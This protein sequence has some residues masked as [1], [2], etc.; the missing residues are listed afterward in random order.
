LALFGKIDIRDLHRICG[1]L[2]VFITLAAKSPL[3]AE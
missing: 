2:H 3:E 1:I